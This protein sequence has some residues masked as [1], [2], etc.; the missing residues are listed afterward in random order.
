MKKKIIHIDRPPISDKEIQAY[1]NYNTLMERYTTSKSALQKLHI[2][3]ILI[4]SFAGVAIVAVILIMYYS[5]TPSE[6][7]K[8]PEVVHLKAFVAPPVQKWDIPFESVIISNSRDTIV[9][10]SSGTSIRFPKNCLED[11]ES[12]TVVTNIEIKYREFPTPAEIFLSGIPMVYDSAGI[13]ST[14]ESA[15]MIE[16]YAYNNNRPLKIKKGY[17]VDVSLIS[18]TEETNY[19]LYYLDTAKRNWIY[20][21]KESVKIEKGNKSKKMLTK[22]SKNKL[23]EDRN[24]SVIK[25]PEPPVLANNNKWH[26]TLD[27]VKG[28]FPE[29]DL[30]NK[31]TFEIDESYKPL[32]KKHVA[33]VWEDVSLKQGPVP[34]TYYIHFK[35][36]NESCNYLVRPVLSGSEYTTAKAKYDSL[37]SLYIKSLALRKET[38]NKRRRIIFLDNVKVDSTRFVSTSAESYRTRET[39]IRSFSIQNFGIWNCDRPRK[40]RNERVI[41]PIFIVN[42]T[43][44]QQKSYLADAFNNSLAT[45]YPESEIRYDAKAKNLLWLVTY[46]NK[47]AVYTDKDLKELPTGV[48][49][50]KLKMRLIKSPINSAED[51]I[52][53]YKKEFME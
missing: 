30:Y 9:N 27:L 22:Q 44:Y 45:Y 12:N 47:L 50:H 10:L 19:N 6:V 43:V 24:E 26:L 14:F 20:K 46:N 29:L 48:E 31:T 11:N 38:E 5:L 15:G 4:S 13:R 2:R 37:Y 40:L 51:F 34:M 25:K 28:E 49:K 18:R 52:A 8:K 36:R 33:V 17:N 35:K 3:N 32:N 53:L 21:G 41:L 42:D 23:V 39:I 1:K 7:I 16:I